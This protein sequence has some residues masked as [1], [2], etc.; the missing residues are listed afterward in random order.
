[1][2]RRSRIYPP[3]DITLPLALR[4]DLCI[5]AMVA[6]GAQAVCYLSQLSEA[7]ALAYRMSTIRKINERLSHPIQGLADGTILAVVVLIEMK[8]ELIPLNP[9]VSAALFNS[10]PKTPLM[11]IS[12]LV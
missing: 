2:L 6:Y 1:M 12:H 8:R 11:E 3:R 7:Q 9:K 10:F 4:D 5:S